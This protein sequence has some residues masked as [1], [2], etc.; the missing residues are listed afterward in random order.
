MRA[1]MEI[2]MLPVNKETLVRYRTIPS[3]VE[4]NTTL[5]MKTLKGFGG[6]T[7]SEKKVKKLYLKNYDEHGEPFS[8]LNFNTSKWVMFIIQDGEIPAG[9]LTLACKTPEL[10]M[11]NGRDDLADIWDIRIHPNLKRQ[12]IGTKLFTRAVEW[13]RSEGYKQLCVET[14]N[15]NV[16][17]CRFYLKQGCNLGVIN[18]YAYS[19]TSAVAG[20][21]QL[22]WF[23]DC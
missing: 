2:Q 17:A 21:V 14:Q 3:Y 16:P 19:A 9:G 11:L 23:I 18:R 6:I 10:R 22:I 20:E 15:V 13:C 4:V 7:F 12:G 5:D 8:W 1:E